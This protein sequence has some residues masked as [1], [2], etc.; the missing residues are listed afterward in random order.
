MRPRV[1]IRAVLRGGV[2][3]VRRT[4]GIIIMIY[5]S[6]CKRSNCSAQRICSKFTSFYTR[7]ARWGETAVESK[8][9]DGESCIAYS[10]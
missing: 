7:K 3:L 8:V 1:K 2:I 9:Y 4:L 5:V 10:S 6:I